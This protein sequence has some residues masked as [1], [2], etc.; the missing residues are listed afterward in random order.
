MNRHQPLYLKKS[1]STETTP[2][3]KAPLPT[4]HKLIKKG[5]EEIEKLEFSHT[6]VLEKK[7]IKI[8][9]LHR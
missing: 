6:S 4:R 2:S 1:K 5:L 9:N 3:R 7:L 8:S